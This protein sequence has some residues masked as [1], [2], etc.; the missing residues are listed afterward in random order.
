MLVVLLNILEPIGS[1]AFSAR[2]TST[3]VACGATEGSLPTSTSRSSIEMG[4]RNRCQ[5]R[6]LCCA[7][8]GEN[9]AEPVQPSRG[10]ELRAPPRRESRARRERPLSPLGLASESSRLLSTGWP[11]DSE[12]VRACPG[13]RLIRSFASGRCGRSDPIFLR[14]IFVRLTKYCNFFGQLSGI[15][16]RL[17]SGVDSTSFPAC[18]P[19]RRS[20][21]PG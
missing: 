18:G 13:S 10:Q 1:H 9:P 2:W 19:K 12:S 4:T 8:L 16:A 6:R 20:S 11:T 21:T 14:G 15:M 17:C 7:V 3:K 5:R